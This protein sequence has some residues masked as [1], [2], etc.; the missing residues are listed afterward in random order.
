MKF[1]KVRFITAPFIIFEPFD[2]SYDL[3]LSRINN[4]NQKRADKLRMEKLLAP[5][6]S[7]EH[8]YKMYALINKYL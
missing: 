6:L 1:K 4:L 3:H 7:M 5:I 8:R 2:M